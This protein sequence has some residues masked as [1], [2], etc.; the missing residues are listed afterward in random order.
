MMISKLFFGLTVFEGLIFSALTLAFSI[1][2]ATPFGL[3]ASGF[4]LLAALYAWD[5]LRTIDPVVEIRSDT[6]HLNKAA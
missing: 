1:A 3:M 4:G 5:R 2:T 6:T